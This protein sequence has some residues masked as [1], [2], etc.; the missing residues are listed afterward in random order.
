M[1]IQQCYASQPGHGIPTQSNML[2]NCQPHGR[3]TSGALHLH[4]DVYLSPNM[5]LSSSS[6]HT[7]VHA[8]WNIW[9]VIADT[10]LYALSS[11]SASS[12]SI[13]SSSE[14]ISDVMLSSQSGRIAP[15]NAISTNSSWVWFE[16]A[17]SRL[18]TA[19]ASATCSEQSS[20]CCPAEVNPYC[21]IISL[22]PS[23]AML[24]CLAPRWERKAYVWHGI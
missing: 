12:S 18:S 10:C 19:T 14:S 7:A 8:G 21:Q 2:L 9:A 22:W 4:A 13:S 6:L 1:Y 24:Q 16:R 3:L 11:S 5:Q 23:F 17:L 20:L 15:P